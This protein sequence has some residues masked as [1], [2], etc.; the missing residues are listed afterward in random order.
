MQHFKTFVSKLTRET[1]VNKIKM[2]AFQSIAIC[3]LDMVVLF[4][5]YV[6]INICMNEIK[7][8][9]LGFAQ[10]PSISLPVLFSVGGLYI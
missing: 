6:S 7:K 2:Q 10:A 4:F 1:V 8:C 9:I 3:V 5:F